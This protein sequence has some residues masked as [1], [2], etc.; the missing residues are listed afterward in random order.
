MDR[1]IL[2]SGSLEAGEY[3]HIQISGS[4]R[5]KGPIRCTSMECSGS[6]HCCGMIEVKDKI[7]VSG[8]MHMDSDLKSGRT[9]ISGSAKIDGNCIAQDQIKIAGA[10]RCGG[11]MKANKLHLSGSSYA[12][13]MEGEEVDIEGKVVCSGLVNGEKIEITF[14]GTDSQIGSIG[15]SI[16]E[17]KSKKNHGNWKFPFFRNKA[18]G[19]GSLKVQDLIEGDEITINHVQANTVVGRIVRI[20]SGCKINQVQYRDSIEIDP[21][22]QVGEQVKI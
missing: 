16:I 4:G 3:D 10:V 20:G 19:F 12:S 22:A 9:M 21:T 6:A 15:G 7:I 14:D 18:G 2:G 11:N 17:I 5:L 13:N 8:S 1:T